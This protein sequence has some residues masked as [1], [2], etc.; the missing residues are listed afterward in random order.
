ME[1]NLQLY[2]IMTLDMTCWSEMNLIFLVHKRPVLLN[3]RSVMR[4]HL[5]K[6]PWR[7]LTNKDEFHDQFK[8]NSRKPPMGLVLDGNSTIGAHLRSK[9]QYLF[10]LRYLTISRAAINRNLFLKEDQISFMRAQHVLSYY[11]ILVPWARQKTTRFDIG[12]TA[13]GFRKKILNIFV[14]KRFI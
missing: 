11:L 14:L 6:E 2:L 8:L 10:C 1:W 12:V 4:N 3:K 5:I 7:R 9:L 13:N